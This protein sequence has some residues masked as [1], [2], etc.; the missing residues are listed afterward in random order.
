M[1]SRMSTVDEQTGTVA[2]QIKV[3]MIPS[4]PATTQM[5]QVEFRDPASLVLTAS[6]RRSTGLGSPT[7]TLILGARD[8]VLVDP[9]MTVREAT[10]L[11]DW[12]SRYRIAIGGYRHA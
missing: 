7:S 2:H 11:A 6:G 12:V 9:L 3:S 5:R 10:A 1:K 4:W 8:A